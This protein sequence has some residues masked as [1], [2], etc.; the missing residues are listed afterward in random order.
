M[1]A[2]SALI[3]YVF[4]P[5]PGDTVT[6]FGAILI[7]SH[8][9]SFAGV[10]GSVMA[11]AGVGSMA[12]F[13]AGRGWQRRRLRK[14]D[15]GADEAGK[16]RAALDRLVARFERHGPA[17]LVINRFLPG[18]RALFFVAAGMAGMRPRAVL[19]YSLVSAALWNGGIIAVGSVVGDN[20]DELTA[21]V[22]QYTLATWAVVG[23]VALGLGARAVWRRRRRD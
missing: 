14:A 22:R 12:A 3:E 6:L 8:G 15:P 7:T 16:R 1:L 5:F 21:L 18:F 4:P 9:W 19:A 11:G 20:L 13:Y 10:F 17:Y 2:A 23:L